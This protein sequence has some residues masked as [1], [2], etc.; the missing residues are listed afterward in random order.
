[1]LCAVPCEAGCLIPESKTEACVSPDWCSA[2]DLFA[3][4]FYCRNRLLTEA[5]ESCWACA[6]SGFEGLLR[7]SSERSKA[8]VEYLVSEQGWAV[9]A[10]RRLCVLYVIAKAK[11]LMK[12]V[13]LWRSVAANP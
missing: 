2:L 13:W 5:Q 6:N 10:N 11:S 8:D 3:D 7:I 4:V 9:S 1:M 12:G